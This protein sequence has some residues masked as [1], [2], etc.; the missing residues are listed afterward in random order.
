MVS[1][2]VERSWSQVE[3]NYIVKNTSEKEVILLERF[4]PWCE[5]C[6][7]LHIQCQLSVGG[8]A[9]SCA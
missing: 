3:P 9:V 5:F 8:M 2:K 1:R 7:L 4:A 6:L